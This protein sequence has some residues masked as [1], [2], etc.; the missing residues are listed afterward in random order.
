MPALPPSSLILVTGASGF[1]ATHLVTTLLSRGYKV[2]GTVRS[3]DKGKYLDKLFEGVGDKGQWEWVVVEDIAQ[4]GVFDEAV[5]GVDGI[6]TLSG[7]VGMTGPC[8]LRR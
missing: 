1:I 4:D 7:K 5:K 6:G 3:Q 2:R 8:S